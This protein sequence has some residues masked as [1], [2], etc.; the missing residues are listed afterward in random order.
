MLA[1][2]LGVGLAGQ[3]G[4]APP[5]GFERL[6]GGLVRPL[7]IAHAGDGSGRLFLLEQ[8]GRVRIHDGSQLRPTPFLDITSLVTCC[9]EQGLLGL[10]FHP[11]YAANGTFFVSYTNL[12]GSWVIA[13]YRVS[14]DP[15]VAD[16]GSGEV[17]LTV[18]QPF[19][20]HNGGHLAFGPDGLLYAASGDGGGAG[21]PQNNGQ[22]LDT[23]LGKILR[24]DVNGGSAYAIPPGNPF[25]DE[26]WSYG[27]RNPWR[28]SFDRLTGDLWIGDVGQDDWEEI[29]F[30]PAG[31]AG[32]RNYGWRFKEGSQCFDPPSGCDPGGLVD[33][34]LEYGHGLGCSVT[35]GHRYR[36]PAMPGRRGT[37]FYGDFCSGRLWGATPAAAGAWKSV[38]LADTSFQISSFGEDEAGEVYLADLSGGEIHRL[39]DALAC[40]LEVDAASYGDGASI[41]ATRFRLANASASAVAAELKIWLRLPDGTPL[42][43]I[44]VG[45]DGGYVLPAGFDTD[46]GPVALFGVTSD[47]P[48]GDYELGCRFLDPVSGESW[49]VDEASFRVE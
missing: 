12:A 39:V 2:V 36:G 48:R 22:R 47:W 4:A 38:E 31:S 23:L 46:S 41:V 7:G 29:D 24:I 13:R 42:E 8:A 1:L 30:E 20:N 37:Y 32:G 5:L 44:D 9:A 26:I 49:A 14:A 27:L 33:P 45:A 11:D 3:A 19:T 25:G 40:D 10:A 28:F 34:V 18:A 16:A 43:L 35:G 17:L 21:D 15:D 6:T